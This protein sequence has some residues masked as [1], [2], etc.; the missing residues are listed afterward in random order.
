MP[1]F[2]FTLLLPV[3]LATF[4]PAAPVP[5]VPPDPTKDREGNPLPEG[6]SA[7]LG[8]LAFRK[9]MPSYGQWYSAD[10]AT[11]YAWDQ[12]K[13]I[14]WD[15]KTGK[16][17]ERGPFP[18]GQKFAGHIPVAAGDRLI[19]F[20]ETYGPMGG[21]PTRVAVVTG[22]DGKVLSRI[23]CSSRGLGPIS[24]V[25]PA[26]FAVSRDGTHA[27]HAADDRTVRAF[28]L[29]TGKE[30]FKEKLGDGPL[31]GAVL[32]PDGK[33]LFVQEVSKNVRR[34]SLPDGKELPPLVIDEGRLA[35]LVVSTDGTL[36]V[37]SVAIL[38]KTPGGGHAINPQNILVVHDL[39]TGKVRG[40][41]DVGGRPSCGPMI[42]SEAI[43]VESFTI[44][45]PSPWIRSL[46]R[47][48]LKTLK[49]DWEVRGEGSLL[50][51]PD[52]KQLAVSGVAGI[53]ILD[54]ATG[55]RLDAVAAH[56]D[57][58][59]WVG[60]SADGETVTTQSWLEV[61]TW[62]RAGERKSF[63]ETPELGD[64]WGTGHFTNNL[65]AWV[66]FSADGKTRE[67]IG[68]DFEKHEATWR[69]PLGNDLPEK[70]F[71]HDGKR[72]LG[73][74]WNAA[75]HWDVWVFD[76]PAGKKLKSWTIPK[77][78]TRLPLTVPFVLSGDGKMLFVGGDDVASYDAETGKE[79]VRVKTGVVG[80]TNNTFPPPL[81]ASRDGSRFAIAQPNLQGPNSTLRVFDVKSGK[82]LAAHDIGNT[83]VPA[84]LFNQTG[85]RLAVWNV[86]AGVLVC[87]AKG[88]AEP[89][90][91]RAPGVA[92]NCAAFSPNGAS[93][94]VGYQDGTA[95]I[96]ELAAK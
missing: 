2:F 31:T 94:A 74:A 3:A 47:W 80:R 81:A 96:W 25:A 73:V 57:P 34:F 52:G 26:N 6:A 51:S 22:S 66:N 95:L 23:D 54:P 59:T 70:I 45:P 42:G 84:L 48:N 93:L 37:S 44:R 12:E 17:I 49:K 61:M 11:L 15:A 5:T 16:R 20:E 82:E 7:R 79:L 90:K 27:A 46:V 60:F 39:T 92:A 28:D 65:L 41:I 78:A 91:L 1:R 29:T 89:R 87:D 18:F 38:Q 86:P 33:T 32:S 8:S 88:T 71:T 72:V 21:G 35:A 85:T 19:S 24:P 36:A 69:M 50:L 53:R 67:L 43:F 30:I 68:W 75:Q 62:S 4:V 10:S 63:G 83:Y 64:V 77:P 13:V 76:G 58:V 14:G 40:E 55:K 9:P 56:S